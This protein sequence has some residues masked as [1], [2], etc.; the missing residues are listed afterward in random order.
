MQEGAGITETDNRYLIFSSKW[1][2]MK[3][4]RVGTY[5]YTFPSDLSSV[6][7]TITHN[8]GHAKCIWFSFDG[9][10]T[11]AQWKGNDF[12]AYGYSNGSGSSVN[13]FWSCESNANEIKIKYE[14][15]IET[16]SGYNPTGEVW[17]FKYYI[18]IEDST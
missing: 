7:I 10:G 5:N 14:E 2:V 13:R 16:G 4:Y 6:D 15:L 8:L 12:W 1:W 17:N 18:F 9:S 11:N 3:T